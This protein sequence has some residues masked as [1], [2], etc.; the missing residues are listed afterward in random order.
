MIPR[1]GSSGSR[2]EDLDR[3]ME[4]VFLEHART[5]QRAA[6]RAAMGDHG[7]AEEATERAFMEALRIWPEFWGWAPGRQRAWLCDRA[8]KRVI[9][10]WRSASRMVPT[11]SV[12]EES[13]FRSAEDIVMSSITLERFWKVVGSMGQRARQVAY[14]AWH[15]QWTRTEIAKH[16]GID[17]ATVLRDL[18]SVAAAVKEQMGDEIH[19]PVGNEGEEA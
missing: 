10:G 3:E 16:L 18:R 12:P 1:S 14:L 5:V 11:E 9:D 7:A 17:R 19:F 8:R 15:E 6:V 13:V 2:H 4:Q